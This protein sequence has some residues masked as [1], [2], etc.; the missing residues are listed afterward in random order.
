MSVS[1][2]AALVKQNVDILDVIGQAVP[3]R[4]AGNRHIGLCPFH[5]EKTPSFQVDVENQLYY[6]FGCGAGG[7]VLSFVMRHQNLS[8]GDALKYLADRYHIVLPERDE[9]GRGRSEANDANRKEKELL[10]EVTRVAADYFHR[11]LLQSTAGRE[12]REYARRRGLSD[13]LIE[14]EKLG[15]APPKWD[16][17]LAQLRS[18]G[19][20]PELGVKAGLLGQ[21]AGGAGRTYDRF[22]NRL[23]F[24]IADEKGSVVAFGGRCLSTDTQD[25]PKY[26]NSPETPIYH[27]G[28]MLYQLARARSEC[29]QVRQVVLV[30]GYMDL[31][32]F[33]ACG[34]F[35]VVAT[36]GTAL[37]IH[38]V[39]LLVR[40]VD[41][42]VLAYDGDDAGERAMMKALPLFLQQELPVS[43]VRFPDGMDPDDFLKAR[44]LEGFDELIDAR[45]DLGVYALRKTLESYD[46]TT[47]GKS[48]VLSTA[49]SILGETRQ[50]VMKAEYVR[51]A[52]ER[53]SLPEKVVDTELFHGGRGEGR[54]WNPDYR[55]SLR[56][57]PQARLIEEGVVRM[58]LK[59][60]GYIEEVRDS[61]A[62]DFFD[63]PKLKTIAETLFVAP[64]S[65]E[66]IPNP[67]AAYDLLPS[68]E[69]QELFTRL[70]LD[71]SE[72][73]DAGTQ[74]KD[75]LQKLCLRKDQF[76]PM[77]LQESLRQAEKE[78]DAARVHEILEQIRNLHSAKKRS[79][80]SADNA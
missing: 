59:Y 39:R 3:L 18:L 40:A 15:F 61:G 10:Y 79:K 20:G 32:S 47:G 9:P 70:L 62:V 16:G 56:H 30:E 43:C 69:L 24:P 34:F 78:G 67:G 50:A 35:R 27:K 55:A 53:L 77:H 52:S 8:F 66:G 11:Q 7:D 1:T 33:H 21:S 6:C 41:E 28:R 44:G 58:M 48:K 38:Q 4:R 57:A 25:E 2:A 45:T 46:G 73:W 12:A 14:R 72:L 22:R 74:L 23:I 17:L 31:L 80:H 42:V 29:R 26:L 37:T 76:R 68:F 54:T 36:L 63:E 75:W 71:S 60:P 5:Q 65:A 13:E 19:I 51:I 64:G 49:R